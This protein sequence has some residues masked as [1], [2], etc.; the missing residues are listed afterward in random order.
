MDATF[1]VEKRDHFQELYRLTDIKFIDMHHFQMYEGKFAVTT[2]NGEKY[3]FANVSNFDT[4][5]Y[6]ESELRIYSASFEN[7]CC[8]EDYEL[9]DFYKQ[10][11][12]CE[13]LKSELLKRL[14]SN[15]NNDTNT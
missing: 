13:Y 12:L 15:R 9:C 8:A 5:T 3:V 1:P 11:V 10:P 4:K 7:L 2:E 6:E 14:I